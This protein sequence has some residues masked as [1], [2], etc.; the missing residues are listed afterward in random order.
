MAQTP[1]GKVKAKVS[2]LLKA[3]P[4]LYYFMPVQGGYGAAT[5]D[6]LGCYLGRFF[7]IETKKPRA[8]PTERQLQTIASIE[9]AGGKT[10][11]IDGDTTELELWIKA[12]THDHSHL[13]KAPPDRHPD[14]P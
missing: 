5:L 11:V 3:T 1:E 2:G 4:N 8:K 7:G 12:T 14:T 13:T 10:F 9:L 6:Y